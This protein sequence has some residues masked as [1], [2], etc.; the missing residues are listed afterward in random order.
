MYKR[1]VYF[2]GG[3]KAESLSLFIPDVGRLQFL[4]N[5]Q[6]GSSFTRWLL[7]E[8]HSQHLEADRICWLM[9]PFFHLQDSKRR[10]RLSYF[11]LLLPLLPLSRLS[12]STLL[13]STSTL[14]TGVITLGPLE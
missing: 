13:S 2:H 12:G 3:L 7:G 4:V 10:W 6:L 1:P 9:V 11:K 5:V 8:G 14:R